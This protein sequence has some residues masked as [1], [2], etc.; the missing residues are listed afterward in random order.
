MNF[1]AHYGKILLTNN[2]LII[3]IVLPKTDAEFFFFSKFLSYEKLK[4][5][6]NETIFLCRDYSNIFILK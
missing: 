4:N 5:D 1:L 6:L 2:V 3:C